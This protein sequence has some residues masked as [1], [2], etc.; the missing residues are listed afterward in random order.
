MN[1]SI[2]EVR[3]RRPTLMPKKTE[4][5]HHNCDN[6]HTW[7]ALMY[8]VKGKDLWTYVQRGQRQCPECGMHQSDEEPI[9]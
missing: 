7:F 4:A 3:I 1:K 8:P 2:N 5:M 6:G 9:I